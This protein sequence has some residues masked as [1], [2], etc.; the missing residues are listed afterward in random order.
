MI[1][2]FC[3]HSVFHFD[4]IC[5]TCKSRAARLRRNESE[6]GEDG[7]RYC[8]ICYHAGHAARQAVKRY[9]SS[10]SICPYEKFSEKLPQSSPWKEGSR[11]NLFAWIFSVSG[12]YLVRICT[13]ASHLSLTNRRNEV[14]TK[15]RSNHWWTKNTSN[16][17]K[18]AI[19]I[20]LESWI[21]EQLKIRCLSFV[22]RSRLILHLMGFSS[23]YF[24]TYLFFISVFCFWLYFIFCVFSEMKLKL[25]CFRSLPFLPLISY[26]STQWPWLQVRLQAVDWP[27]C[28]HL[29]LEEEVGSTVVRVEGHLVCSTLVMVHFVWDRIMVPYL[30]TCALLFCVSKECADKCIC[31]PP[32]KQKLNSEAEKQKFKKILG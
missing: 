26:L 16:T 6:V 2:F 17:T 19:D 14:K 18:S 23:F 11:R 12:F 30:V 1:F 27:T 24:K 15:C 10:F 9:S 32:W 5:G 28:V 29:S 22:P 3:L 21:G 7:K 31:Q 25:W 13:M 8:E 4:N 20:W